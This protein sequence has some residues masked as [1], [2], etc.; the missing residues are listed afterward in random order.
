MVAGPPEN[1]RKLLATKTTTGSHPKKLK[2]PP[3]AGVLKKADDDSS[4][5]KGMEASKLPSEMTNGQKTCVQQLYSCTANWR[6]NNVL[7]HACV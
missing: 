7:V 2:L 5:D 3:G 6:K 1:R 4:R